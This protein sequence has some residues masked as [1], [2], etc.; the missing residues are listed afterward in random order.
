M[1]VLVV[2]SASCAEQVFCQRAAT[3]AVLRNSLGWPRVE[4]LGR[5]YTIGLPPLGLGKLVQVVNLG[6]F[7]KSPPQ[8]FWIFWI[9]PPGAARL[10]IV[11]TRQSLLL[12]VEKKV[13]IVV[14]AELL[15]EVVRRHWAAPSAE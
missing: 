12:E 6:V 10:A 1:S 8:V 7:G 15:D 9:S 13:E 3:A 14:G 11:C 5:R 4:R 2:H